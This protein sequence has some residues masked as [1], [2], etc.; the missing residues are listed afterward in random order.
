MIALDVTVTDGVI[1]AASATSFAENPVSEKYQ[2]NFTKGLTV[3]IGKKAKD[4]NMDAIG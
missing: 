4:F 2:E 3:V 1:T